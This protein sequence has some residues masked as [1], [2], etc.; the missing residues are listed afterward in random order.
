M[1]KRWRILVLPVPG[2]RQIESLSDRHF[3]YVI[4]L[5]DKAHRE[6]RHWPGSGVVMAWD[7]ADPAA[8][9]DPRAFATLLQE[10]S[11]RL[12]LFVLVNSKQLGN[13][14]KALTALD[15]YKCL[16]EETRLLSLLLIEQEGELCV[17]E[18]MSALQQPQSKI[19]RH[20]SQLRKLGLLLDRRQGQWVYYRLHPLLNDWMREVLRQTRDHN[21]ALLAPTLANLQAMVDRPKAG[22]SACGV[23]S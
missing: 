14:L 10:I 4:S 20:L 9:T 13:Q 1:S 18:L 8:S 11:E 19:S 2:C 21:P 15:F 3:D 16:A 23:G 12:R 22:G 5:C 7:F 6:C 17:C